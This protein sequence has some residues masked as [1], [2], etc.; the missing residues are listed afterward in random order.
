MKN[1]FIT[2][3]LIGYIKQSTA[4]GTLQITSG[5]YIKTAGNANIVF[6]GMNVINNGSFIQAIGDGTTKLTGSV[7]TTTSG[8]GTTTLDKL[9]VALGSSYSNTLSRSASLKNVLTL[10]SG[11]LISN[12][13]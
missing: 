5:A 4:Q 7:N 9:E 10:S 2:F 13:F 1:I 8:T 6:N 3:L 12:G 11:Q